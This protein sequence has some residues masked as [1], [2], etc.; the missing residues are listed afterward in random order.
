MIVLIAKYYLNDA[1]DL[2]GITA[3][4]VTMG[5][6]VAANEPGCAL[7]H[8]SRSTERDDLIVLY[9]HY[10]DAAALAG[11]RE[12]PHFKE[13]IEGRIVPKLAKRE[14]ELYELLVP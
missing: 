6:E 9:E 10:V 14:R 4:L 11:H 8:A 5:G 12:T 7:Y 1:A 2:D 3:D 13:I